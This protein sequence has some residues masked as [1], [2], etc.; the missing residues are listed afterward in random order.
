MNKTFDRAS[1]ILFALIGAL[2][3]VESRSIS[4]S[5]Y[6]S[7]VGPN[8]FPMGLGILLILLGLRL[9]WE[10]F[11][12][13]GAVPSAVP[14]RHKRFLLML[15]AT[16]LYAW[17]LEEIGY[18]IGTFL[19]LLAGFRLMGSASWWKSAAVALAFSVGVYA[20]YVHILKGTLPGFPSWL[21]L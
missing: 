2:F 21:G 8:L 18:V 4:T 3:V 10:T 19:F 1:S 6:G 9:F 17:F 16:V 12:Y 15:L 20:V 7:E 5:A 11:R 13:R 14:L